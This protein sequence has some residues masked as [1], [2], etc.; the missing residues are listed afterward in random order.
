MTP[1]DHNH[2]RESRRGGLSEGMGTSGGAERTDSRAH[3]STLQALSGCSED[4]RALL[5]EGIGGP[6]GLALSM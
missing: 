2:L 1:T 6:G 5:Q 3:A 4:G